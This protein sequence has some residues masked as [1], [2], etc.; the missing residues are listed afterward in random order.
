VTL[1]LDGDRHVGDG[2][3]DVTAF[4]LHEG[5]DG[6]P[7]HEVRH[8]SCEACGRGVFGIR[9]STEDPTIVQRTCRACGNRK[10]IADS[11]EYWS[12]DHV[13]ISACACEG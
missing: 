4:L 11:D 12:D 1:R 8:S 10:P 13:F 2:Q 9:G 5:A 3:E 6:Y 7:V